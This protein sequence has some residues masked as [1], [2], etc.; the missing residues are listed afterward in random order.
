MF[1]YVSTRAACEGGFKQH[2]GELVMSCSVGLV[3]LVSPRHLSAFPWICHSILNFLFHRERTAGCCGN[4]KWA[5]FFKSFDSSFA[6]EF[7]TK[8]TNIIVHGTF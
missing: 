2:S 1:P 5:T 4:N 6:L 3:G 7:R 8:V